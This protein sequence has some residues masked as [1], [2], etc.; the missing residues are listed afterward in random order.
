MKKKI[1]LIVIAGP[2]GIGKSSLAMNLAQNLSTDII[3][4]DS[5]QIYLDFDIG[6]A[7]PDKNEQSLVKH[8][9]IDIADPKKNFTLAEYAEKAKEIINFVYS[10]NKIPMLVGGTGLYI[11]TLIEGFNVPEV[12]PNYELRKKLTEKANSEEGA[13]LLYERALSIDPQAMLKIHQND[14]I[15]VIRVIEIFETTGKQFSSLI[16]KESEPVYDLIYVGLDLEREKLYERISIRVEQMIEFGLIGEVNN[17]IDKYGSDLPLL[18]TINYREVK[19]YLEG[20]LT[21]DETKE[22]MKKNTRNFAKRQLTWFRHDPY[23]N[24]FKSE[25]Q[26]DLNIVREHVLKQVREK[27]KNG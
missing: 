11:K 14:L 2:T 24:F 8:H 1:P 16:K 4:A 17:I 15:R 10:Q 6:T 23:I 5:R 25:N 9:L 7:K 27:F 21:L 12:E 3:S 18:K 13:K 26:D 19:E 22:L 20:I